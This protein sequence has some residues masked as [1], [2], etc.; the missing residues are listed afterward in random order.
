MIHFSRIHKEQID[1]AAQA[2]ST[3]PI[4]GNEFSDAEDY[5]KNKNEDDDLNLGDEV[6]DV[7]NYAKN[8]NEDDADAEDCIEEWQLNQESKRQWKVT[9]IIHPSLRVHPI[10]M[11]RASGT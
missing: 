2:F 10:I 3:T 9:F 1:A 7:E 5:A 6:F 11:R 4:A 8:E